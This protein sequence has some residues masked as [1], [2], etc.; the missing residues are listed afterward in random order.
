MDKL[1][2][3]E[4]GGAPEGAQAVDRAMAILL[5]VS[6][7][8]TAGASLSQ[9]VVQSGLKQPTVH[10]LLLA[11]VRGGLVEQEESTKKYY[12]GYESYVLGMLAGDRFGIQQQ[13]RGSVARLAHVSQ[14]TAFLTIRR[15]H[16]SVCM[17]REEGAYPIR[18]HVLSVGDRHPLGIGAGSIA[19]L[20]A[21]NDD[22]VEEILTDNA[23]IYKAHYPAVTAGKLRELVGETREKGFSAHRGLVHPGSWGI[24]VA[25]YDEFGQPSAA[26][27]IGAVDTRL[28]DEQRQQSLAALMQEEAERLHAR[29][30]VPMRNRGAPEKRRPVLKEASKRA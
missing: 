10:R 15:G 8:H 7:M 12:L 3:I 20:A 28:S 16:F 17:H 18:A 30:I 2:K 27:S 5:L 14:D 22:E 11:L 13:A 1:S 24:G 25:V 19:I 4:V 23:E 26:L 9:L 21:L 29:L 6:K